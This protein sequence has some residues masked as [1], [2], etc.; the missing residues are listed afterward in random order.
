MADKTTVQRTSSPSR[1]TSSSRQSSPATAAKRT[2][3][4]PSATTSRSQGHDSVHVSREARQTRAP[5]EGHSMGG[6]LQGLKANYG[7]QDREEKAGQAAAARGQAP[8]DPQVRGPLR[9]AGEIT[10]LAGQGASWLGKQA[11]RVGDFIDSKHDQIPGVLKPVAAVGSGVSHLLGGTTEL[12]GSALEGGG[13]LLQGN[14]A[15]WQSVGNALQKGWEGVAYTGGRG[16]E[17]AG[18][19]LG[20]EKI[21]QAGQ[22]LSSYASPETKRT[23]DEAGEAAVH[24][25]SQ[26]GALA[27]HGIE[28]GAGALGLD[29]V[30]DRARGLG[31]RLDQK[32]AA[33]ENGLTRGVDG[34]VSDRLEKYAQD[35]AYFL[36]RDATEVAG[37]LFGPKV[38]KGAF[39]KP[40]Q[41]TELLPK[42]SGG[43]GA[44]LPETVK[45]NPV[46]GSPV[47]YLSPAEQKAHQLTIRRGK[48]YD[49][50]GKPFDTSK[51]YSWQSGENRA[52]FV[53][54]PKGSL[55]ASNLHAPGHFHHSSLLAGRPVAGAGEL[56]V[57][58]GVLKGLSNLSG[59]YRPSPALDAQVARQLERKGVDLRKV[60]RET[61]DPNAL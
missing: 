51:G 13:R 25:G 49:A 36:T 27:S 55:Y 42:Y 7:T 53:M 46:F 9:A 26:A 31:E 19:A 39:Q 58:N 38:I 33:T 22:G 1:S 15:S 52:I 60:V 24:Y 29:G 37:A 43:G 3:Q 2:S 45:G 56:E 4:A 47:K 12:V 50:Q 41:T 18:H 28:R 6:L 21:E 16:I 34:F 14:K 54:D 48:L 20:S 11:S 32:S 35:P 61:F 59:H 10:E 17:A 8:G 30:A 44:H 40:L 57:Q 5:G 23:L